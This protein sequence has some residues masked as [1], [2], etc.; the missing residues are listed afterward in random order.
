MAG[1]KVNV[2]GVLDAVKEL[3]ALGDRYEKAQCA[4]ISDLKSRAPKRFSAATAKVYA[5]PQS[6]I[7]AIKSPKSRG[8]V[9]MRVAG[10]TVSSLSFI[11]TGRKSATDWAVRV[12]GQKKKAVPKKRK[13]ILRNG[14]KYSV[15]APY[16]VS[17]ETY[18]GRPAT[19]SGQGVNR[20]FVMS[21]NGGKLMAVAATPKH[22]TPRAHGVTSL[23]Q[24]VMNPKVVDI[25][26]PE[27]NALI[28]DRFR[29]NRQRFGLA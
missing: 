10:K 2:H 25:W 16:K 22:R 4:T 24:A 9:R 15:P 26:R 1:L 29:H 28:L 19:I 7:V 12:N 18:K 3:H 8:K 11:F 5:A 17:I 20:I 27:L 23:P 6:Y 21:G 14:R 13:K